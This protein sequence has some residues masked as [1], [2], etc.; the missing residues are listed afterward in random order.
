VRK[1]LLKNDDLLIC[2]RINLE[3]MI[4]IFENCKDTTI[5]SLQLI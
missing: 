2:Y 3:M 4:L 1:I 5:V